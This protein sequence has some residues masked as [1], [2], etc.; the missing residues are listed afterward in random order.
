MTGS[1]M[2][3]P[4]HLA[5]F[6]RARF[7]AQA[8]VSALAGDASDRRFFRLRAPG[9]SLVLMLHKEP[10][11]L[12]SMPFFQAAR[13]LGSLGAPVPQIVASFPAEGILVV[14]DLGDDMLQHHLRSCPPERM[15]F[16]YLQAVQLIAFL[17]LEGTRALTPDLHAA[18]LALDREKFLFELRY[19]AEHFIQGLLGG[20]LTAGQAAQLD[21]WFVLL[22][23]EVGAYRRVLCHRDFHS[24][25]LMVKG[26]RLFMVDFQDARMGPF[27]YDLASLARD[28]YVSLPE[29]LVREL[30]EFFREASGSPET[31]EEFLSLFNRTCLQRHIK[32][33]G[34]FA[35]QVMLRGNR[36]YLP[37][38]PSTLAMVRA[39]LAREADWVPSEIVEMFAGPLDRV[40]V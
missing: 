26:D 36:V 18:R 13:F 3:V 2:A 11:E 5:A 14:Q 25:N 30:I 6:A 20:A 34:T 15:R 22:A 28:A 17:Q 24:R 16:L 7:G 40:P 31:P 27:T 9:L 4:G 35:S 12:D 8:Q 10:F 32:A 29:D 39:N 37:W 21:D 1:S 33:V 38:I 19:F 23:T